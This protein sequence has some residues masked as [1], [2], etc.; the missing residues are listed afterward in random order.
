MMMNVALA[1]AGAHLVNRSSVNV[2]EWELNKAMEKK[3]GDGRSSLVDN[4]KIN[5]RPVKAG[6]LLGS[7][8]YITGAI[9]EL[10]WNIDSSA[11]E[12]GAFGA[13]A[14]GFGATDTAAIV[15]T[16]RTWLQVPQTIKVVID[17]PM[18]PLVTA[19]DVM[20]L[21]CRLLGMDNAFKAIE[22]AGSAVTA[23]G[24]AERMTL[25]NMAA[26]LG[27]ETSIAAPD[28][29]TFDY[30]AATGHP[31]AD[32]AAARA[33]ASDED[34]RF[35]AVHHVDAAAL[36]PQV[37]APHAPANSGAA[38]DYAGVAID[39]AYIGA[40]VGAKI[41]DLR[42]AAQVLKDRKV[43]PGVRLLVAP[44]SQRTTETAIREGTMAA[45]VDAG[46][47]LLSTGCGACAGY[48][49]G[50]LAEGETCIST[51]NR[52]FRG[53]M[54]DKRSSVYLGSPYTVAAAAVAGHIV[55][56]RDLLEPV[57]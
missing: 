52:N 2:A 43:A 8:H 17:G 12:A 48:G 11:A 28:Q 39:Q 37:A 45:L 21:L 38:A 24:M 14:A 55:D 56:P 44:A 20:L 4:Q 54:G 51:T 6:V 35:E 1:E 3:L 53:R 23:M 36:G 40:C 25:C 26:E 5:F 9:T 42:M 13:Y 49:A 34:A 22:F 10:N 18:G 41:E 29:V 50:V 15:A 33:F 30:L 47:I 57:A 19:K 27:A 31:V 32:E 46:A 7:T 16:G